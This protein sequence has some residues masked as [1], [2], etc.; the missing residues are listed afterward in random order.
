MRWRAGRERGSLMPGPIRKD[1][2]NQSCR[3]DHSSAWDSRIW[4]TQDIMLLPMTHT[5]THTIRTL[6]A[7][8][9]W[10]Y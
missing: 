10:S 5:H 6:P 1:G 8:Y 7:V 2:H 3:T 9:P 4:L